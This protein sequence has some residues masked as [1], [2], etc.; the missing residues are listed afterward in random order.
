M[1]R[2]IWIFAGRTVTLLVLP[3]RGSNCVPTS[4]FRIC[5]KQN[6]TVK[7]YCPQP[8]HRS[9]FAKF[10]CG[11]APLLRIETGRYV[12]AY[13]LMKEHARFVGCMS[14]M[15]KDILFQC[16]NNDTISKTLF[17][18]A[19]RVRHIFML[20]QMM[21]KEFSC[22][23]TRIWFAPLPKAVLWF[24]N[25]ELSFNVGLCITEPLDDKTNKVTVRPVKTQ[26]NLG[27]CQV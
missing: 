19:I 15:K 9:D 23:S 13:Q 22:F 26:I 12:S 2:L 3:W 10:R 24:Y 17:Q 16:E 14:R 21:R 6:R 20:Y 7:L 4:Y 18:K 8:H 25:A 27:I 5:L 11:V 1:P